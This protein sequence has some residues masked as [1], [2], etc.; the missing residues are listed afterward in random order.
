MQV[1]RQVETFPQRRHQTG[2]RRWAQQPGHV[3][4]RQDVRAG[5]DDLLGQAEVV[6]QRVE[7]LGRAGEVPGVAE[8]HLGDRDAGLPHGVDGRAHLVHVVERIEDPEDVDPGAR[9]LL[10]ERRRDL[11]GIGRV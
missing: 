2:G 5:P 7:L 8:S 11:L 10:D 3:L 9:R 1:H 6:V 4:D